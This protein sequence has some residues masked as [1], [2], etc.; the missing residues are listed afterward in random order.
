MSANPTSAAVTIVTQTRVLPGREVEFS[1]WQESASQ[2]AAQHAGFID[3]KVMP[4]SPPVQIDWVIL[5][6][7]TTL[8]AAQAWMHSEKRA[9][10]L[11]RAQPLLAG[12]D[13]V[14]IVADTGA[15]VMPSPASA[16]ISTRVKPGQEDAYRSWER[17]IAAAQTLSPGFQGYRL[18]P[19]VP[20]VQDS[21][22]GIVRFD[23]DE[24]LE[25]WMQ[26][27]ERQALLKE[28]V[29]L[30]DEVR[31]RKVRTGFDQWFPPGTQAG[32]VQPPPWK[33]N[34]LVLMQLYPEVFL[35]GYL[36][37]GPLLTNVVHMPFW[38][39]LFVSN[40]AGVLLL[41]YL[42]P[43]TCKRFGWWL[44]IDAKADNASQQ[45]KTSLGMA[46]IV[47]IYALSLL[48]FSQLH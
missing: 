10:L 32:A 44:Q 29:N 11:A 20:G 45:K 9:S 25:R 28:G 40:V 33:M 26:S 39:S 12:N 48:I 43:W 21:W 37:Q 15:G 1:V 30:S 34:M 35:F 14:H 7:F 3:Q 27:P 2:A 4:P 13:D 19:P 17:R 41:N 46:L 8:A 6:R 24:N 22:L 31:M 36:I 18:E 42:V 23:S 5:Q 38:L 16:V 47:A